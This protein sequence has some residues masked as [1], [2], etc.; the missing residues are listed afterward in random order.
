[1]K[2]AGFT[3][4]EVLIGVFLLIMITAMLGQSM[5]FTTRGKRGIEER[6]EVTHIAR[7]TL[8]RLRR[9]IE[10]AFIVAPKLNSVGRESSPYVSGF[11]GHSDELNFTSF[12]GVQL[13][14]RDNGPDFREVGYRLESIPD[15]L[16][17]ENHYPS[18]AK[19][20]VRREDASPDD[21]ITEGGETQVL[22]P[23]LLGFALEYWDRKDGAW[24]KE[25]DSTE[26]GRQYQLPAAVR[27]T[28]KLPN[29]RGENTTPLEFQTSVMLGL[30]PS[31][32][33]ASPS[34]SANGAAS[35]S[36]S[37]TSN[38]ATS[39]STASPTPSPSR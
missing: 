18:D 38:P 27:I 24:S 19:Q 6:E 34:P 22:A 9:D 25:W 16:R 8:A 33:G 4:F 10:A 12:C 28:V 36:A 37:G 11:I 31:P 17:A 23:A 20:L 15:D 35:P 14:G 21:R 30:G 26:S 32:I 7:V 1:M 39:G 5:W 2:N 3:L 29:P 13:P